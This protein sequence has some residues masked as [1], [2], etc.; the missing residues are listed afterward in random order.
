MPKKLCYVSGAKKNFR[1]HIK[2]HEANAFLVRMY[3]ATLFLVVQNRTAGFYFDRTIDI[4]NV[5]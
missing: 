2:Y 5:N 3:I 4:T 1:A